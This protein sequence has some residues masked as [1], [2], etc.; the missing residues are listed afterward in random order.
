MRGNGNVHAA[1][2]QHPARWC[3]S[4]PGA[5]LTALSAH[6]HN[7]IMTG[8]YD[9]LAIHRLSLCHQLIYSMHYYYP[10]SQDI[11]VRHLFAYNGYE[12]I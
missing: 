12:T 4:K 2:H 5:V 10:V 11:E 7:T 1:G 9:P 8:K 3:E 6:L